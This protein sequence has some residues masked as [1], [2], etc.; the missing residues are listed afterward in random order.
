MNKYENVII[1]KTNLTQQEQNK[2]I[3]QIEELIKRDADINQKILLGV[4]KLAYQIKKN[5]EGF[6]IVY[7]FTIKK[8]I[9]N[10]TDTIKSLEKFYRT[11]DEIIKFIIVKND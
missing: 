5:N 9:S 7:Q 11:H 4:K 8:E 3:E 10:Y 6:Y 2:I 1:L